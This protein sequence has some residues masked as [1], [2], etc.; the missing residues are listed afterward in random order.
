MWRLESQSIT[1]FLFCF[2]KNQEEDQEGKSRNSFFESMIK[3]VSR[4]DI[5]DPALAS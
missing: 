4:V 2:C 3:E 5:K 1:A